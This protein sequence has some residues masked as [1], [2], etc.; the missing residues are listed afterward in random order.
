MDDPRGPWESTKPHDVQPAPPEEE[1]W[2]VTGVGE[3]P[4]PQA[5]ARSVA[6]RGRAAHAR[7]TV[8]LGHDNQT[9]Y[10]TTLD[11]MVRMVQMVQNFMMYILM[12]KHKH[13]GKNILT[14]FSS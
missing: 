4:G 12:A 1:G 11:L 13:K 10:F 6:A 9:F 8:E 7:L 5:A 3:G 14:K 2:V